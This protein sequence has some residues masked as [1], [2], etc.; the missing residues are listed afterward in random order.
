VFETTV[1]DYAE[2]W[3]DGKLPRELGQRGGSLAAG[4]NASN[5][6]LLATNVRAGQ[7]I[8]IAVFGMNGPISD[9]PA[10]FIWM[11]QAKLEFFRLPRAFPPRVAPVSIVRNDP[12]LDDIV[13]RTPVL[14]KLA[15]GFTFIE[16]PIWM[17]DGRL[18]FSAPNDNVIYQ[19]TPDGTLSLWRERTGYD[20]PDIGEYGQPGSNGLSLDPQGRLVIAEHGRHRISRLDGDGRLAVLAD[21]FEGKRLN[22]PNDL[23]VKSDGSIYFTDP[24]FGLPGFHD[25]PRKALP[26]EGVF[27]LATDGTLTLLHRGLAGPNGLAFSP[28]ER[29]LYVDNW[30]VKKKVVMRFDVKADG[31]LANGRVFFDMTAAP[32]E[33]ALDGLKV[34]QR[35]NVYVS[36][37]GGVWILSPDGKHLGTIVCPELP[38]NFAWGDEDGRTLY[39]AARGGLYRIRLGVPGLRPGYPGS[40]MRV[41]RNDPRFD[42]IV[43]PGARV[44]VLASG[45]QWVEGPVYRPGTGDLLFS[46]IPSNSVYSLKPGAGATLFLRPSGYSGSTPFRG[47]E[48]GANGLLLDPQGRLIL[49]EHGD[50]RV[51]RLE[52]DG[53]RTVLLDRYAGKRINSPN[54]A[55]LGPDGALYV[56]DPPFGLPR[57]FDDP[58]RELDF[59][60]VYRVTGDGTVSLLTREVR[61]PNGIAFSPDGR[62]LYVSNA[63]RA[64][65]VYY[66]FDVL[67]DGSLGQRRVLFDASGWAAKWQGAPDGLEVDRDGNLIAAGPGG[68]HVF[69]PDGSHLGS[70]VSG[71]PVSNVA[72]GGDGSDLYITGGH[73][74]Y[75]VRLRT[76]AARL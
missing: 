62:T 28:D 3:V 32:G 29:A 24:P 19:W 15:E 67:A 16:G 26:Y 59:Q 38:A 17:P 36:G 39:L 64:N 51:T 52:A 23:V 14:E 76:A 40:E 11:R 1:D 43:P 7:R 27:R 31:G 55:T 9:P 22:S 5:R 73:T 61:A 68:V 6:L 72:W 33:E 2:I 56:T 13:P 54:D 63:D 49:C 66:A 71:E 21:A 60:G 74:L 41:E 20:A 12:A 44:E 42:A 58:G 65:A 10:N 30:D 50:R 25:D 45:F 34:D 75:R 53:S 47:P 8:Q 37:P 35:G 4:W 70:L 48:P 46:D 18:L 69:A 57:T